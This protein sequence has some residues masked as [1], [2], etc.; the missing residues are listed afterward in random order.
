M[1]ARRWCTWLAGQPPCAVAGVA[2]VSFAPC[3]MQAALPGRAVNE[4]LP[5]AGGGDVVSRAEVVPVDVE[6]LRP[7]RVPAFGEVVAEADGLP[8]CVPRGR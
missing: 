6:R 3:I 7:T 4:Q 1:S 5:A 8:R 2:I